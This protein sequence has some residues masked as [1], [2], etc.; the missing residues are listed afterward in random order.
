[1]LNTGNTAWLLTSTALVLLMT[2]GLGFF[3]TGLVPA[4]N[5][6]NT[7]KMSFI[8]LAVIPIVWALL[9]FSLAFSP[10]NA[11]IGN[12]QW[13]GL[14]GISVNDIHKG[15]DVP[16]YAFVA[17]QMMFA[18]ISP[19]I[20]SGSLVGRMRFR[21]YVVFI[22]LW[23]LL[24]YCPVAH[25]VWNDD[26]WLSALGVLDFAGG[27]VVHINAGFAGLAAAFVLGPRLVSKEE[28][29]R[30]HNVPFVLLGCGLLWF[31]WLG[32]NAGSAVTANGLASLAVIT[33]VLAT[34]SSIATWI[35]LCW[36]R[37][38]ASSAVGTSCAA[39]IGLVAITPAAGFV[40]PLSAILIGTVAAL[41]C[42]FLLFVKEKF[43]INR[44]DDTL[45]VFICHGIGGVVGSL[46]TG[47]L[48]T[49]LVNKSGQNGLL[50]G[51]PHLFLVQLIA[52]GATVAYS[53][54]GT[55]IILGILKFFVR[56][57]LDP[58]DEKRGIDILEHGES[59]YN[60]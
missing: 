43:K 38:L 15:L 12:W 42:Y 19:A 22:I 49:T 34:A 9:G 46:M 50:Y 14:S 5:A 37:G 55:A 57:R 8:C 56:L 26:G 54:I 53:L 3:Y 4:R 32:F 52:V 39:V 60:D 45:D 41:I 40:T 29:Q 31:G 20:I 6:V 28:A 30:P 48:A 1:M 17:F 23:S 18:I 13:I 27:T 24:I 16:Q 11:L 33:T 7:L 51:N 35:G 58:K 47:L 44:V 10:D 2:P 25:W 59:A 21:P 36:L